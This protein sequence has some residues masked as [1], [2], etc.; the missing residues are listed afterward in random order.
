MTLSFDEMQKN[1]PTLHATIAVSIHKRMQKY[2]LIPGPSTLTAKLTKGSTYESPYGIADSIRYLTRNGRLCWHTRGPG[3]FLNRSPHPSTPSDWLTFLC[4]CAGHLP[5]RNTP[6][7][8]AIR[9]LAIAA[10]TRIFAALK[11][12]SLGNCGP[13]IPNVSNMRWTRCLHW[14][15][16]MT[17]TF[18]NCAFLY[19]TYNY[20]YMYIYI[21]MLGFRR[22]AAAPFINRQHGA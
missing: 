1:T 5:T 18:W 19:F 2:Q 9:R 6:E 14:Q 4:F 10:A 16:A 22:V 7:I 12:S 15:F 13:H 3:G 17:D 8:E 20:V 11:T 21:Y